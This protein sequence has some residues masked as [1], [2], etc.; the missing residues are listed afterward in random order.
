MIVSSYWCV[1]CNSDCCHKDGI[2]ANNVVE[3]PSGVGCSYYQP[4]QVVLG[5]VSSV[6][7]EIGEIADNPL[8]VGGLF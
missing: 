3:V 1:D 8:S 6:S 7:V 5:P 4:H 2:P